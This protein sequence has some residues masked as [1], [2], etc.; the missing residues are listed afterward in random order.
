MLDS[1][2]P[3]S[4][5]VILQ[6]FC[7][8]TLAREIPSAVRPAF[9]GGVL[10]ALVKP[11]GGIRPIAVGLILRRLVAKVANRWALEKCRS[12]LAPRQLGAGA[13][14][15]AEGMAHA[16]QIYLLT[17]TPNQALVKLNFT[18]AF[19]SLRRDVIQETVAAR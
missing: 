4:L 18:N 12:F 5:D 1:T 6:D 7:N 9:F 14:G 11:D 16:A 17:I 8:L 3:G 13:K 19:N 15:G 2:A 10:Y